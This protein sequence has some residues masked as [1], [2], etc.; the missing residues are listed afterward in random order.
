MALPEQPGFP[1][2]V[3]VSIPKYGPRRRRTLGWLV[4]SLRAE[5]APR[6]VSAATKPS[7]ATGP[8]HR[9]AS[10]APAFLGTWRLPRR[11][12]Q[13]SN[14]SCWN[15][16]TFH[17][18]HLLESEHVIAVRPPRPAGGKELLDSGDPSSALPCNDPTCTR[19]PP[20]PWCAG[21]RR[22]DMPPSRPGQEGGSAYRKPE[23]RRPGA[24]ARQS[25]HDREPSQEPF[26]VS[27]SLAGVTTSL[28]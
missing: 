25:H 12:A 24:P 11:M 20:P 5:H 14:V 10:A 28:R 23:T 9:N 21:F 3:S 13:A 17:A 2:T 1:K 4:L 6:Q 8:V 18:L 19:S 15:I 7:R 16:I 26:C 27:H 22:V